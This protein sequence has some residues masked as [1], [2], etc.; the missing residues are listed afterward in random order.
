MPVVGTPS[1]CLARHTWLLVCMGCCGGHNV[2]QITGTECLA[3]LP[4][5]RTSTYTRAI[6]K[7]LS[8]CSK[9]SMATSIVPSPASQ[10]LTKPL[11]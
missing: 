10:S 2:D 5:T 8:S 6:E 3:A 7:Q 4:A 11:L 9:V 1:E